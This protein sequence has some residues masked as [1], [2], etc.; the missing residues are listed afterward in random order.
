MSCAVTCPTAADR[1]AQDLDYYKAKT[2]AQLKKWVE[3]Q[4]DREEWLV[5]FVPVARTGRLESVLKQQKEAYEYMRS[6]ISSSKRDRYVV[7]LCAR[8]CPSARVC[9]DAVGQRA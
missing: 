7:S 5:L 1:C 9:V 4:A 2:R 6:D 8:V 3:S